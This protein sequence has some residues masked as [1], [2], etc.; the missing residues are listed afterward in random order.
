MRKY[1][2]ILLLILCPFFLFA[3]SE[4]PDIKELDKQ[5]EEM[6]EADQGV[7]KELVRIS[8]E[9]KD[10]PELKGMMDSLL[11]VMREKDTINQKIV[12]DLLDSKGWPSG[13]SFKANNTIFLIIQHG[14]AEYMNKYA[15]L[16]EQAYKD[17]KIGG[18]QYAI[19]VDRIRMYA[20]K[21]QIY[22]SQTIK[23]SNIIYIWPIEDVE[24]VESRRQKMNL[25]TMDQYLEYFKSGSEVVWDKNITIEELRKKDGYRFSW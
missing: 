23:I 10:R 18:S 15:P 24:N 1:L 11:I 25:P 21:P 17:E 2:I 20:G 13:L 7:R 16:V 14:D 6:F 5:L 4:N 22:G 8:V 12:S 19:F 9:Y 3:Q